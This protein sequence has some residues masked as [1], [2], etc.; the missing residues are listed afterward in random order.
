MQQIFRITLVNLRSVP[1]RLASSLVVCVGVA[2]VVAVLVT[3]LAMATG[4]TQTVGK[5]G[6][7][8]RAIVL[9][10]GAL[11]E[12]LSSL[13]RDAT[14]AIEA[15]AA[16]SRGSD[17]RPAVSPEVVL[18][19]DLPRTNNPVPGPIAVRG[20]TRS[21]LDVHP[22]IRIVQGRQ[23][24]PG[25]YEV[26][27]GRMAQDGFRNTRVG[28]S[29]VFH[30][31]RWNVVGVFSSNGD[32]RESELLAD[33][34]TLMS[35]SG[36]T[37]FNAATVQLVSRDALDELKTELEADPRLKVQVRRESEYYEQQSK[38]VSALLYVV[39]YVVGSI[40]ALGAVFGALDT[41]YTAVEA[42][43]VEIATLR[44]IGFGAM[45]IVISVLIEALSLALVG[46]AVGAGLAWLLFSGDAFSTGGG[47]RQIAVQLDVGPAL[48]AVGALWACGIGFLGGLL[49]A[50]RAARQPPSLGLRVA[51]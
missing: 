38:G 32:V 8:D 10:E 13:S 48:F 21:G 19:V 28:D 41:M 37:V 15:S 5:S 6:S 14:L 33:A 7:E 44:A 31:A 36:R 24:T 26:V 25:R 43:S 45:P 3:V 16:I 1:E 23:F 22:E 12:A 49:P 20:L 34:A 46:A 9:R 17:G 39:A 27:V 4:L 50:I 30:G 35:A 51:A 29:V 11:G 47:L 42:R 40:M 2:G 18:A